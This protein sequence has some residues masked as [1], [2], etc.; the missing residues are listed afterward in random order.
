VPGVDDRVIHDFVIGISGAQA[1]LVALDL[2]VYG[3]IENSPVDLQYISQL[4]FSL[5]AAR[6]MLDACAAPKFVSWALKAN[7]FARSSL[8]QARNR[9]VLACPVLYRSG[10]PKGTRTP[11]FAVKGIQRAHRRMSVD[12]ENADYA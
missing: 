2:G 6:A 3:L 10:A 5:R 12:I 7:C 1:A 8:L 11:V 4:S 9:R